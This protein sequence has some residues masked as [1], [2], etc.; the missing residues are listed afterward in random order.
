MSRRVER[1]LII[2]ATI[3]EALCIRDHYFES[4]ESRAIVCAQCIQDDLE[5]SYSD[6][7]F[8]SRHWVVLR[9]SP[10]LSF[11]NC[12]RCNKLLSKVELLR[13]T[14]CSICLSVAR[15]FLET[16]TAAEIQEV[17]TGISPIVIINYFR[18]YLEFP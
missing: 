9:L 1:E 16:R 3:E 7:N 4:K 14:P 8:I 6:Y 10:E 11:I 2:T 5:D 13:N 12:S 18:R 17:I 15:G